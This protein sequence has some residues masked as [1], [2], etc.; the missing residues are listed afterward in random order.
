[1]QQQRAESDERFDTPRA[2]GGRVFWKKPGTKNPRHMGW[3]STTS[4]SNASFITATEIR[5]E[6]GE[7]VEIT[8]FYDLTR[9]CKVTRTAPWGHSGHSGQRL[10][11]VACS[12]LTQGNPD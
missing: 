1:M 9:H 6:I 3:L 4:M 12:S 5:P 8:D 11:L 10:S 2:V 7:Q